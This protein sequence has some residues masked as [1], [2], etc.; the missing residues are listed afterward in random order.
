[1]SNIIWIVDTSVLCNILTIPN[2]HQDKTQ[3]MSDFRARIT[4]EDQFLLPYTV[5]IETGNHIGHSKGNRYALA[6]KFINNIVLKTL[7]GDAPWRLMKVPSKEDIIAWVGDFPVSANTGKGFGDHT[8]VKEWE[9]MRDLHKG[10]SVRI[11]SL[12][13]DLKG[14]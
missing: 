1:M 14:Y 6:E 2:M 11:W 3:V 12:D 8:I 5:L 9:E 7:E 13:N 4:N 10:F